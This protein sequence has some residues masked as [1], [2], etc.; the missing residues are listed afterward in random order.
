MALA[1]KSYSKSNSGSANLVWPANLVD[2]FDYL[3]IDI[4]KFVP[5]SQR[6]SPSVATSNSTLPI[7][8]TEL[9]QL[10]SSASIDI[11]LGSTLS[12]TTTT[13][14]KKSNTILLPIPE[15]INYTDNPQ[16]ADQAI[17]VRG[18]FGPQ[19]AAGVMNGAD[20]GAIADSV[21][22]GAAA[23]SVSV[24][25]KMIR[26]RIGAD[27]N[28]ITQNINGKIAN[29]YIEQVFGGIG[30]REFSFNWKLVPRNSK[31]QQS[32]HAIIKTLRASTLPNKSGSFGA[33]IG[34]SEVNT[35]EFAQGS[36]DRWLEVPMVFDL[37]WKSKGDDIQSMPKIK[38]CVC[39]NVQVSYT[40][41]NVWA[42]HLIDKK[43]Y[44]VAYTLSVTFGE[45]EIITGDDVEQ[46]GY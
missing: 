26:E 13:K 16:W 6:Q 14:L 25:M 40:P 39:K 43:P 5:R 23:G 32:I 36:G 7:P 4:S 24:I 22:E 33:T 20:S 12:G 30:M 1:S 19:I 28:A 45:M 2:S 18:R 21:K 11:G 3:Q 10:P 17:G 44:P 27:P 41:D 29:P 8:A 42:T 35:E 31:E 15:D 38:T 46:R 37:S 34:G 9:I